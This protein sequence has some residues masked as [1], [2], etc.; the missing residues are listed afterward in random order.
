MEVWKRNHYSRCCRA[1]RHRASRWLQRHVLFLVC[2]QLEGRG[3]IRQGYLTLIPPAV[4]A[5]LGA[6]L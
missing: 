4:R 6:N 5:S 2:E 3:G 1:G